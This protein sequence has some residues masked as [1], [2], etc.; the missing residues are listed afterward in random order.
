MFVHRPDLRDRLALNKIEVY[1][2]S[3]TVKRTRKLKACGQGMFQARCDVKKSLKLH[4]VRS[5]IRVDLPAP[6]GPTIPTRLDRLSAQVTSYRLGSLR[7]GYVNV[8]LTIFIM[9]RVLER[10]P[11]RFPGGGKVNLT[12]VAAKV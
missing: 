6:L 2:M 9:A 12:E 7:P 1:R 8:Q 5:L 3:I 4:T 11:M 10:T